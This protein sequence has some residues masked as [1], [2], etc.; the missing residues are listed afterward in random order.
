[1]LDL[2]CCGDGGGGRGGV[3]DACVLQQ[4]GV[5]V[6][7]WGATLAPW[8]LGVSGWSMRDGEVS[9]DRAAE[10]GAV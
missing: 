4:W 5:G 8:I 2:G 10:E 6:W 7:G 3:R 1:M 9:G